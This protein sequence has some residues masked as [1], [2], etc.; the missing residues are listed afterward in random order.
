MNEN[1]QRIA[2]YLNC[3]PSSSSWPIHLFDK[4]LEIEKNEGHEKMMKTIYR[5]MIR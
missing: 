3:S 1:Y 5:M 4:L 2:H